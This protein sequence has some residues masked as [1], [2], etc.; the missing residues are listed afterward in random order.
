M[1]RAAVALLAVA[2]LAAGCGG[3]RH[4][5]TRAKAIAEAHRKYDA[6]ARRHTNF[7]SG[8]CLGTVARDWVADVAHDPRQGIDDDP[9]NQCAAFRHG[10]AHHFVELDPDGHLIRAG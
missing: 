7:T 6:A 3:S 8:P 4:D 10:D 2:L 5:S 1:I 9:K